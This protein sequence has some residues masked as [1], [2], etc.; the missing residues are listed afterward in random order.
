VTREVDG[1]VFVIPKSALVRYREWYGC[2]E[3]EDGY[4]PNEGLKLE[5]PEVARGII[6]RSKYVDDTGRE[7]AEQFI[8]DVADPSIFSSQDGP[9]IAERFSTCG[10]YFKRGDN[11]RVGVLGAGVGWEQC[12]V[13]LRGDPV[14]SDGQPMFYVTDNCTHFIRT[15]PELQHDELKPEDLD[16][17]GEDHAADEW[18]YGCTSRPWLT[19]SPGKDE[20]PR[21]AR[22][23]KEM[24]DRWESMTKVRERRI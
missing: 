23:I 4:I 14:L 17:D 6:A 7:V 24:V 11:T 18:R 19:R 13:R 10:I 1:R 12:R 15:V 21:G 22:T 2:K 16:T 8:Y 20:S 5:S 3:N 9:S